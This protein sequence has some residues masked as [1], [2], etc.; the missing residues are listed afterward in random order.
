TINSA[1]TTLLSILE[2]WPATGENV[3]AASARLRKYLTDD[4]DNADL[5]N[6][7]A[8]RF[9]VVSRGLLVGDKAKLIVSESSDPG[10]LNLAIMTVGPEGEWLLESFKFQCA[11]CFGTGANGADPC[12]VCG[13]TGWG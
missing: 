6:T 2:Q 3:G 11:T 1:R 12:N 10:I 9:D 7:P 8:E 5:A 13:A 4:F